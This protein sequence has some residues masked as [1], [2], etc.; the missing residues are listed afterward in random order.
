[1]STQRLMVWAVSMVVSLACLPTVVSGQDHPHE[2]EAEKDHQEQSDHEARKA[3]ANGYSAAIAS[4]DEH[5]AHVAQLIETEQLAKV[6][7]AAK[8]I[9]TIAKTLAKLAYQED[10]GVPPDKVRE[11]NLT[12]KALAA[13]WAKID[14]AGDSGDLAG[15]KKVYQEMVDLINTLRKYVRIDTYAAAMATID[16]YL[17]HVALLIETER[18][19]KVHEAAKP[20]E[21]IAKTL[22]KLAYEE[23]SGVPKNKVRD[24]NLTAKALA[25]TWAKIDEAGDSG[26]LAGTKTVYQ[27]MVDLIDALKEYAEP[28]NEQHHE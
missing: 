3:D 25:A 6:H 22:A 16:K 21:T 15:T 27:E 2:Q 24:V 17:A 8:P 1:M 14:E 4:I 20:I 7:E 11:I 5:L 18:L 9:E 26:D 19:A 28:V 13:T 23:G 10:S 12:A